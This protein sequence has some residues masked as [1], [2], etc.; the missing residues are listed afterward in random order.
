MFREPRKSTPS[1]NRH[2]QAVKQPLLETWRDLRPCLLAA[3][4]PPWVKHRGNLTISTQHM[5]FTLSL[6]YVF[7]VKYQSYKDQLSYMFLYTTYYEYKMYQIIWVRSIYI[8][9]RKYI[10]HIISSQSCRFVR[11]LGVLNCFTEVCRP[12]S[13]IRIRDIGAEAIQDI[14]GDTNIQECKVVQ[15]DSEL[16][17]Y[18][19]FFAR[20]SA[21]SSVCSKC[22]TWCS[23]RILKEMRNIQLKFNWVF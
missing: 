20:C 4:S 6:L 17:D 22:S 15:N 11:F 3:G 23:K 12:S 14:Y 9:I 19:I 10:S 2:R 5:F 8:Y 13:S 18:H 21:S 7:N 1:T 16:S